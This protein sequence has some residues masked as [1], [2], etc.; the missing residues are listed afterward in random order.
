MKSAWLSVYVLAAVASL[1][2]AQAKPEEPT[3]APA[4]AADP[5]R[6]KAPG[7]VRDDNGLKLKLVWCPPGEFKMGSP[8][9][10]FNR[11]KNEDQVEV[12][13]TKGFW[14][15][16]YEVTQAEWKMEMESEPWKNYNDR[17]AGPDFPAVRISWG[18]AVEFCQKLTKQERVARR[19]TDAWEYMLPSEAAV[20]IRLPGRNANPVQLRRHCLDSW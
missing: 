18:E 9:S 1:C 11:E 7:D 6:G 17:K 14:L 13:L 8:K 19:L 5:M 4:P 16:K 15:G 3:K 10:E 12:I 2:A 20:G